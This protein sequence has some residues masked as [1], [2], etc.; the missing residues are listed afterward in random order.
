[1][2]E[3]KRAVVTG[4]SSGI[5]AAVTTRLLSNGWTVLGLSRRKPDIHDDQFEWRQTDMADFTQ[6]QRNV[7]A[8]DAVDAVVHAAGLQYAAP[9]GQLDFDHSAQMWRIHVGAA[10]ALVDTLA[11]RIT[12][13][14]RIVL[15]GSR[16][17]TGNPGKSQYAG[18]KS[19]LAGMARSWAGELVTRG[20]TVNVVAPGPTDTPMLSDPNRVRTPPK[21][22]PMG[23]LIEADEVAGLVAFLLGADAR[24]ITGQVITQCAGL[25]L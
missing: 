24:S 2:T 4:V 7:G 20:I 6:I 14:G 1:M 22:P 3:P 23:R 5:G 10:E 18:T 21:M 16:T 19:A 8:L 11:S 25:S 12:D 9:L 13:G 17:M 15:V